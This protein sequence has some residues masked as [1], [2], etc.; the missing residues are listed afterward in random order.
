M[1]PTQISTF[2]Q[3]PVWV[4]GQ[5]LLQS[6]A[7]AAS[8]LFLHPALLADTLLLCLLDVLPIMLP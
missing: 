4:L 8:V 3:S 1:G 6:L 2:Q 7:T 5:A